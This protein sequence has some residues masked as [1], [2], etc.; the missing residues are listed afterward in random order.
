[1]KTLIQTGD[2]A[3]LTFAQAVLRDADIP[4]FLFDTHT[5][6]I[7]GPQGFIAPRLVVDREDWDEAADVLRAAGLGHELE[8]D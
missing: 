4:S 6:A 2:P 3:T 7:D 5:A 8:T 1:M